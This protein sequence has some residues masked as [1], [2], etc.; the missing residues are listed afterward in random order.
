MAKTLGA[1]H[2]ELIYQ[3]ASLL[4]DVNDILSDAAIEGRFDPAEEEYPS[5]M[6]NLDSAL[7]SLRNIDL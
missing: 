2:D 4:E 5:V 7:E 1:R 3:L 6:S